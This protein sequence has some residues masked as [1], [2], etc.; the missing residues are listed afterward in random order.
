MNLQDCIA[1]AAK[2]PVCFLATAENDQPHV[3]AFLFWFADETGFYFETFRP[4][5]VC[6]Q[7]RANP[8]VE[9]CFFNHGDLPTAKTLRVRGAAEFLDDLR[10]KE[11]LIADMPFL[12][13]YG[14]GPS[15]PNYQIFRLAHG[16]AH[17]WTMA[18]ILKEHT[19][20]HVQF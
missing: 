17:F 7:I 20:E 12:K 10:L 2:N 4:K 15:D 16:D 19:L 9:I 13:S 8:K 5:D 14:A 18:D 6:S 11:R 3:R 1:F